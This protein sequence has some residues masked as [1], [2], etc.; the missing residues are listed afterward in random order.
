MKKN[1]FLIANFLLLVLLINLCHQ[2]LLSQSVK[3]QL[4]PFL[5]MTK[6]EKESK[7]GYMDMELVKW[8]YMDIN[9]KTIIEPRFSYANKFSEGL[10]VVQLLERKETESSYKV[11]TKWGVINKRGEVIIEAKFGRISEFSNGLAKAALPKISIFHKN[12]E[13]LKKQI[14]EGYIDSTGSF[15]IPWELNDFK[16]D[17]AGSFSEGLAKVAPPLSYKEAK[18]IIQDKKLLETFASIFG[19]DENQQVYSSNNPYGFI[20]KKGKLIIK[21]KFSYAGDFHDGL[22]LAKSYGENLYG[23]INTKGEFVIQAQY[24]SAGSFSEGLAAVLKS[25]KW[26]FINKANKMRIEP[27]FDNADDFSEGFAAVMQGEKYGFINNKGELLVKA[28]YDRVGK[29]SFGLAAVAKKEGY[30]Y[31]WGFIN[32]QGEL[33]IPIKF[34]SYEVPVFIEGL[35]LVEITVREPSQDDWNKGEMVDVR[36]HGYI[37]TKGEWVYGPIKGPWDIHL[38]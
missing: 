28:K 34:T 36:K 10:A 11:F 25:G 14:R 18:E 33:I 21:N 8:G 4:F 32:S 20:N 23:F 30:K 1:K 24:E 17:L 2:Q 9:G 3:S 7:W 37:N 26:G 31:K 22:V 6:P 19:K 35:A 29:F 27:G 5:V 15:V 38:N 12:Y 16:Y 13:E